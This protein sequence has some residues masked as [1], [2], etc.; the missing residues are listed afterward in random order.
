[1]PKARVNGIALAYEVHGEGE[2]L[3]L[4]HGFTAA[5]GMWDSQIGSFSQKYRVVVYDARGHG[6][7]DAPPA[8]DPGY[9]I[10][11]YVDDQ[12]ALME[13]LGIEE[14]YIGGLS[15]G[16]MVAMRFALN[17]PRMTRALL[18]CDTAAGTATAD[19]PQRELLEEQRKAL[20]SLVRSRGVAA[21]VGSNFLQTAKEMGISRRED[22]PESV[23]HRIGLLEQMTA[24][25]FL[26][27]GRALAEQEAVLERLSEITAPTL[28]LVGDKDGL[29]GPSEQMKE[30]LPAARFV[31]IQNS[32]HGTCYWQ[33]EMFTNAVLD[34]LRDV[35]AGGQ[36]AGREER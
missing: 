19:G 17:H 32:I 30:R 33:P 28:I 23:Q 21:V 11:T 12:R 24:D 25:G 7:S 15:M 3:I 2:P 36:V 34:F 16:G 5:R 10:D 20:E 29:R 14:A 1:M 8:D 18:L 31:I 4:A 6:E 27:A 35:H 22:L 26:G 9:T 13:H